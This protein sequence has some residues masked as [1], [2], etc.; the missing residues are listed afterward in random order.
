MKSAI[1]SMVPR[2]TMEQIRFKYKCATAWGKSDP[3]TVTKRTSACGPMGS[4]PVH[5]LVLY[6]VY[7]APG[8]VLQGL[9]VQQGTCPDSQYRQYV[10]SCRQLNPCNP[11]N[12]NNPNCHAQGTT[13]TCDNSKCSKEMAIDRCPISNNIQP[14]LLRWSSNKGMIRTIT[15][16]YTRELVGIQE[17][18][19]TFSHI[20]AFFQRTFTEN[21]YED[22]ASGKQ[23]GSLSTKPGLIPLFVGGN[24]T[25]NSALFA[26]KSTTCF[27]D[28]PQCHVNKV[29][30]CFTCSKCREGA[31]CQLPI[32][33]T[34]NDLKAWLSNCEEAERC[35]NS[36]LLQK[37]SKVSLGN[38]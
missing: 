23:V 30:Y 28:A 15:G 37:K 14:K 33:T 7:C 13:R 4:E 26:L 24:T 19:H 31:S 16:K 20:T 8:E 2:S 17:V 32:Q 9:Q 1:Q 12:C 22:S 18:F 3:R 6:T 5:K 25:A 36:A 27:D 38:F 35:G 11:A 29:G 34:S 21:I 10:A